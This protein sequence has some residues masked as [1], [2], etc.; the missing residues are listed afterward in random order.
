MSNAETPDLSVAELRRAGAASLKTYAAMRQH[1]LQRQIDS[2]GERDPHL[3]QIHQMLADTAKTAAERI[4]ADYE[5][6]RTP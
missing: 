6:G 3:R 5:A 1:G 2:E 4:I